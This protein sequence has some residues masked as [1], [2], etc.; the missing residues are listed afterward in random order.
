M[1]RSRTP[2]LVLLL[3]LAVALGAAALAACGGAG[4]GATSA[5]PSAAPDPVVLLV[6][7]R[8]VHRSAVDA[9]RAE[10]R[11]AGRSDAEAR[12]EKEAVR[13]ELV[14]REAERLGVVADPAEVASRRAA[15]VDQLGGE[16]ALT[17]ALERVPMTDDQLRSGLA[18]GVL[19]EALQDAKFQDLAA[20]SAGARDYYDSHRDVVPPDGSLT[21]RRSRWRPSAIAENALAAPARRTPVRGGRAAVH[22]RPRVQG[23]RRRHGCRGADVA[24]RAT[25]Q[26]ASRHAR[27][28]KWS[29]RCRVPAA[30]TCSRPPDARGRH[31][32]VLRGPAADPQASSRGASG[33]RPWKPGWTP[34]ATRP[35]V[36]RP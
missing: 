3:A 36:T 23:Q 28:A 10:F 35:S 8:P 9:V 22:D 25:S 27:T 32:A 4:G 21:C 29:G 16:E 18:D 31:P 24:S 34:R 2:L 19:R 6:D 5:S 20:T 1:S 17:S 11:L 26:G 13:R 7:G 14:R 33:S 30:G 15:M 12:A